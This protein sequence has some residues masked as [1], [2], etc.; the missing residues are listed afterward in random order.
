LISFWHCPT[1]PRR[2]TLELVST[3]WAQRRPNWCAFTARNNVH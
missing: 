1:F 2:F 3:N